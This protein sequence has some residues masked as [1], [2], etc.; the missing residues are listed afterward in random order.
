[1]DSEMGLI[2]SA[3]IDKAS[4]IIVNIFN[5]LFELEDEA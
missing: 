4:E 3:E 1:M 2:K 5:Q